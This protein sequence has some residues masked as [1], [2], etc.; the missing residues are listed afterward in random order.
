MRLFL[1]LMLTIFV[2]ST[3][4]MTVKSINYNGMFHISESVALRML[5]FEVGDDVD[6]E[7]VNKAIKNYFKQGYFKDAWA[8]YKNGVLTFNFIEK[9]TI[10]KVVLEG[11]KENDEEEIKSTVIQIKKGSLYNEQK[12]EAAKKRIISAMSQDGKIDS[13]VE[14][15]KEILENGSLKITFVVNEGEEII[16]QKLDYNG[17]EG[18][19]SDDFDEVIANKEREWMG[20]LFGRND[21]KMQLGDLEYDNLRIRDYYMQHGYLDSK[22]NSPF[23]R[24]NFDHY[25]AIMSYD[26]EEG[27]IYTVNSVSIN[28]IKHVVNEE[29]IREVITLEKGKVFNIKTF[30]DNADAIKTLVADHSYAFAQVVPDLKKNKEDNTVDVVFKVIPGNKVKIRDVIIS[31]NSRTLDRVIRRELYLGPGDMYSLTDLKDSRNSLG[32]LGFFEG[33][34]IEEKRIDNQTMDLELF[35]LKEAPCVL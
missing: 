21:G 1:F 8:D 34:T 2:M 16:I 15:E 12:I 17:V 7:A 33:N 10:S 29:K 14:V 28:Q 30:R 19:D 20:W 22:V 3:Q 26:I 32:R 13:V 31:G 23:V 18:L 4:A 35:I 11:W 24:V 25:T 27:A 5:E 6:E 9:P